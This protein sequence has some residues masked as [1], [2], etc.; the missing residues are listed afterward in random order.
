KISSNKEE[1]I[2]KE[3]EIFKQDDNHYVLEENNKIV[4]ILKIK[5][6]DRND[7]KEYGEVK[8]LYLLSSDK[9]KGYGKALIDIAFSKLKEKGFD[10]VV[11]GCLD[12]NPSNDFYKHLGG[13]FI[14]QEDWNIFDE[15]YK[16][17][18]Y[19]YEI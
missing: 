19:L 4:G 5:E 2:K 16:E 9:G 8:V 17:N 10:R 12:G 18:I 3:K 15:C 7:F 13:K 1:R 6:S 14:K 11:I